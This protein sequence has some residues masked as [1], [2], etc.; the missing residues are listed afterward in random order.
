LMLGILR[1]DEGE[2]RVTGR[3]PAEAR[4]RIG[5]VPQYPFFPRDFPIT[6]VDVVLL[7]CLGRTSRFGGFSHQDRAA[8]MEALERLREATHARG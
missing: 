6:V 2:I 4:G 5:Y 7:G 1:P 8:A 3:S